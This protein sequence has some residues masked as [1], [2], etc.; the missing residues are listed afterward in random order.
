MQILGLIIIPIAFF[1]NS[2]FL[3]K[4]FQ[5]NTKSLTNFFA[6]NFGAIVFIFLISVFTISFRVVTEIEVFFPYA[7]LILQGVL[8]IFYLLNWK[9]LFFSLDIN[10]WKFI[11]FIV[12]LSIGIIF[13]Y[14]MFYQK[15]LDTIFLIDNNTSIFSYFYL[16][17]F[18]VFEFSQNSINMFFLFFI[19]IYLVFMTSCSLSTLH[20]FNSN[21]ILAIFKYFTLNVF[22]YLFLFLQT[23]F[24]S[25]NFSFFIAC[26]PILMIFFFGKIPA[27]Q[28]DSYYHYFVFLIFSLVFLNSNFLIFSL[29]LAVLYALAIYYRKVNFASSNVW[30]ML[31][32]EIGVIAVYYIPLNIIVALVLALVFVGFIAFFM[33]YRKN[34]KFYLH[35]FNVENFFE[36]YS[37]WC[38]VFL[39]LT[40]LIVILILTS[41][42]IYFFNET[43]FTINPNLLSFQNI[44]FW[45]GYGSLLVWSLIYFIFNFKRFPKDNYASNFLI[46]IFIL[47]FNPISLSFLTQ[48][49]EVV[50]NVIVANMNEFFL[51]ALS[52]VIGYFYFNSNKMQYTYLP[53]TFKMGFRTI[54]IKFY[55]TMFYS[56]SFLVVCSFSFAY[57]FITFLA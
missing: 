27:K 55:W 10:W 50:N 9:Q 20:D 7:I 4:I 2:Y 56:F 23:S 15:N 17:I 30:Q 49:P 1:V 26:F 31:I 41:Q 48:I 21:K 57:G 51:L 47:F 46:T 43:I 25:S 32:Y 29:F 13:W 11:F 42:G 36:K 5:K 37:K 8:L 53:K 16:N 6:F 35:Q 22:F 44:I 24:I 3:G 28:Y 38:I 34:S 40:L 45:L 52:L 33:I 19:P 39:I 14:F 18:P 54:S 12:S